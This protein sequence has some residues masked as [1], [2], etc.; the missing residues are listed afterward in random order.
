M[1]QRCRITAHEGGGQLCRQCGR[2]KLLWVLKCEWVN[3]RQ[4]RPRA[5]ARAAIVD[6][7]ERWHTPRQRRRLAVQQEGKQ[8]L[9]QV[10]VETW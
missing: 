4:Y 10:S 3:R 7:I 5:E 6:F 2:R 9:T 8:R 1:I